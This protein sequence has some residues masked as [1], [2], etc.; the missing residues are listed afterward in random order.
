M[1]RKGKKEIKEK[2]WVVKKEVEK[3]KYGMGRKKITGERGGDW[4]MNSKE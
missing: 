3:K 1:G 2:D 4:E